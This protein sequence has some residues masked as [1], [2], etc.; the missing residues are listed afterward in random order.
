MEPEQ[1]SVEEAAQR[2][3]DAYAM[4]ENQAQKAYAEVMQRHQRYIKECRNDLT[5]A[6]RRETI[7]RVL[8]E[9]H[10]RYFNGV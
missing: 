2:L 9:V 3:E 8:A 7:S 5:E 6:Q 4:A 1:I 10:E